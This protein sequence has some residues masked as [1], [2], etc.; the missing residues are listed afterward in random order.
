MTS[1]PIPYKWT[2]E[3]MQ[4]LAGR[5]T[6]EANSAFVVG[7]VYRLVEDR[8]IASH[9][10]QFA[11]I[12]EAWNN[13]P[14]NMMEQFPTAEHLRKYA[15]IKCG[16]ANHR[17]FIASSKAEALR[18]AAFLR[19]MNEYAIVSVTGCIVNEFTAQS[20]SRRAMGPKDFQASKQ[21]VL[22]FC[23]NLIGVKMS[24]LEN[25]AEAAA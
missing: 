1:L 14:E 10:H 7:Q 20:Q 23:A 8:S 3:A 15:L 9:N 2:G 19:P 12:A 21:A 17:Q 11:E 18:I 25:N 4:P 13:L 16:F 22:E 6:R 24:E 5:A